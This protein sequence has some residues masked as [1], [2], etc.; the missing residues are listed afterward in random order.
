MKAASALRLGDQRRHLYWFAGI[1]EARFVP[2]VGPEETQT[3]WA[4]GLSARVPFGARDSLIAKGLVGAGADSL[5]SS[6]GVSDT[7]IAVSRR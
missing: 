6:R 7:G 2:D 3:V 5:V 1:T 4:T